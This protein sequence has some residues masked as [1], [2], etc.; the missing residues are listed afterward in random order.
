MEDKVVKELNEF[1]EG[2]FM[3]IHAYEK[4]IHHIEDP[5]CK[6]KL[7]E[8]QKEHKMHAMQIAERIQDLG[9][10]PADDV[11]IKGS[12]AEWMANLTQ[13]T[14]GTQHILK[15]ALTGEQRGIEISQELVKGDL[16]PESL[17]LVKSILRR[18]EKHAEELNG[19]IH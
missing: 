17:E 18:D 6:D 9:G 13:A 3:A 19:M 8:I 11:G 4:Y 15:D 2:N 10:I 14:D 5:L 16:D 1:L 12:I 7:Q